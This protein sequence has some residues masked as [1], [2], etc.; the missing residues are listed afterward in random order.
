MR[1]GLLLFDLDGTILDTAPDLCEAANFLRRKAHLEPLPYEAL[2]SHA[3]TGA[4]GLVKAALGV[5][6]EDAHYFE[7]R[8]AFLAYYATH[9]TVMSRP[10]AGILEALNQATEMGFS[11]GIVTNKAMRLA[12][13]LVE[14]FFSEVPPPKCLVAGDSAPRMKPNPDTLLMALDITGFKANEAL[15]FGD[16]ARDMVAANAAGITSVAALWG[17][18]T[19]ITDSD[20][21]AS[22]AKIEEIPELAAKLLCS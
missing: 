21:K 7:L 10:F 5:T 20:A 16:E 13:P 1:R 8:E 22:I 19:S 6:P 17:Y 2:R 4:K 18:G 12:K 3:G 9:M 15:Y 11:W 14:K